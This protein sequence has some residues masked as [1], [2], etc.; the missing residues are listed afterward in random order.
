MG[1]HASRTYPRAAPG[2]LTGCA[3]TPPP[4]PPAPGEGEGTLVLWVPDRDLGVPLVSA[5]D[6]AAATVTAGTGGYRAEVPVR[7][8][9]EV[10]V[11]PTDALQATG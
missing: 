9:Y 8:A 5:S 7:G 3:T 11:T 10:R 2:R 1:H 4:A 6:G